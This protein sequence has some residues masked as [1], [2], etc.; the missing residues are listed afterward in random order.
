MRYLVAVAVAVV[1]TGA[2]V[3]SQTPRYRAVNIGGTTT[4]HPYDPDKLTL[5]EKKLSDGSVWRVM[6][7][8]GLIMGTLETKAQADAA[9]A[10]TRK[11]KTMCLIGRG[12]HSFTYFEQ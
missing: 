3:A 12:P 7:E 4:C 9:L 10:A 1:A 5:V 6:R 11:F 2:V 8:D